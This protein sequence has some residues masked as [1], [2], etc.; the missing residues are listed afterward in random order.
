MKIAIF[1]LGCKV[2]QY[3]CNVIAEKL[4]Y[5]GNDVTEELTEADIYILNTCAVTAEAEKKSR[6][7][8]TRCVKLNP[9]AKIFVLG[10]ASQISPDSFK[11]N[12]VIYIAGTANKFSVVEKIYNNDFTMTD[13]SVAEKYEDGCLQFPHRTRAFVKIQDGCNN[14][15]SYCIIPYLRGRS[16]SRSLENIINEINVLADKTNEIVLTGIDLMAYGKDN[17]SSLNELLLKLKDIDIRIRLGSIYAEKIDAKL[18]DT[19]FRIKKF[20]PHFHLSLQSGD[21]NVLKDMNRH[22]T[23][24]EYRKKIDLIRTYDSNAAITTDIIIGYPTETDSAFENTLSFVKDTNFSDLHIFPF[25]SR[26]GTKA[27]LLKPLPSETVNYRKKIITDEKSKLHKKFL[28]KNIGIEQEVLIEEKKNGIN[29]GYSRNYIK[30]YTTH[31]G[32]IVKIIPNEIY[33]DGLKEVK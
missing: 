1:N 31:D 32:E 26:Q 7:A 20:C 29:V 17:G 6:Q 13:L 2:N 16:R 15:C 3:E 11:K 21:N 30:I 5:A 18:L 4:A 9:N 12:R 23:A 22:Y 27:A 8:I 24:E 25:S 19:M 33:K 28:S 10:C 14:F